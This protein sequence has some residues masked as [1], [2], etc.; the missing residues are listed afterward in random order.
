MASEWSAHNFKVLSGRGTNFI[1]CAA[2]VLIVQNFYLW[3]FATV[4]KQKWPYVLLFPN[5]TLKTQKEHFTTFFLL[6]IKYSWYVKFEK[7]KERMCKRKNIVLYFILV[8]FVLFLLGTI[9]IFILLYLDG[10][11]SCVL[12]ILKADIIVW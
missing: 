2:S 4:W 3:G 12:N 8:T 1:I 6:F 5:C 7:M 10:F 11:L 9:F